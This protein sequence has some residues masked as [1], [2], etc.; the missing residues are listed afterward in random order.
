MATRLYIVRHGQTFWNMN[1]RVQGINDTELTDLGIRQAQLLAER[2]K[3]EKI[4]CIYSS[5][6]TRAYKTA[7]IIAKKFDLDVSKI[8]ELREIAFGVWEGL[9]VDEINS[10]YQETYKLWRTNP[11]KAIIEG[12]ESLKEV[13]SRILRGTYNLIEQNKGKNIL[14]VSHGTSIKV[15]ILG[16]LGIDLSF[17]PK[18]RLDNTC[19]NI[20]DIK[21][22]GKTVLVLLNDTCHLRRDKY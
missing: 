17:Y 9:T 20:V 15:L 8:P 3:D 14:L 22:D 18:I 19:L 5:D 6:L 13:Q 11:E 10:L 2:L 21:D 1:N 7:E 16:L 4:D 12:A